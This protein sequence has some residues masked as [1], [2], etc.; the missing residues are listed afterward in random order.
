V[1]VV[2]PAVTGAACLYGHYDPEPTAVV[3]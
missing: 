3:A 2:R 1:G